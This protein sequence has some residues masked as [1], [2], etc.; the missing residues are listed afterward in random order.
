MGAEEV[1][2]LTRWLR[3]EADVQC[4][5]DLRAPLEDWPTPE[6]IR[7]AIATEAQT[8]A[9]AALR[10]R[11]AGDEYAAE[12]LD[13]LRRGQ[14]C[15]VALR[16]DA[17]V[18]CNWLA[19]GPDHE[20]PVRI[21]PGV[22]EVLCMDAFTATSMRGRSIHTA[23]Q[24]A[25][26]AWAKAKRYT[27]AYTYMRYRDRV[28]DKTMQRMG[29]QRDRW[30]RYLILSSPALRAVGVLRELVIDLAPGRAPIP[31]GPWLR[32]SPFYR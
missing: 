21:V 19:L 10:R 31:R 29:W 11:E 18:G 14:T 26:L 28:T 27:T 25:M 24:H 3:L 30:P 16:G 23:L 32:M 8:L 1:A 5:K 15:F 7:I 2:A 20:G 17:V 13:R 22:G 9:A 4:C 6:G 12:Y